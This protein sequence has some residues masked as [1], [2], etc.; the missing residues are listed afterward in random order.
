MGKQVSNTRLLWQDS[1][2]VVV[3]GSANFSGWR[4]VIPVVDWK[5][6]Y[7]KSKRGFKSEHD[8]DYKELK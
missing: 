8:E 4:A 1:G 2:D 6:N 3:Q 5:N 7:W